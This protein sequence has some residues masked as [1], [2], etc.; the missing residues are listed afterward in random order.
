MSLNSQVAQAG[1]ANLVLSSPSRGT[2]TF[3]KSLSSLGSGFFSLTLD[4]AD[5]NLL[6][7]DTYSYT[8]SQDDIYLKTGFVRLVIEE[9]DIPEDGQLDAVLDFLLA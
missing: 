7:D 2:I 5:T 6:E 4:A 1:S 8:L 9:A 3:T